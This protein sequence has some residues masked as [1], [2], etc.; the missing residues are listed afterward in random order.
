LENTGT[1]DNY[2]G[3]VDCSGHTF[4]NIT[5]QSGVTYYVCGSGTTGTTDVT[6]VYNNICVGGTCTST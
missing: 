1:T 3:Y 6:I 2:I 4:N 5:I